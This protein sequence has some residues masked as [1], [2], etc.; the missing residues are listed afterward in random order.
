MSLTGKLFRDPSHSLRVQNSMKHIFPV[1]VFSL[2]VLLGAG[3]TDDFVSQ[4][5][6]TTETAKSKAAEISAAI[7]SAQKTM[8]KLQA[9]Y[10][11]LHDDAPASATDSSTPS[12]PPSEDQPQQPTAENTSSPSQPPVPDA[13]TDQSP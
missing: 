13:L 6:T 8:E 5:Q 4:V 9:I 2:F 12:V 7:E 10:A 3:C 1:A 11:I